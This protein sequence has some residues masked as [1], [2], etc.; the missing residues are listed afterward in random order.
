MA[1]LHGLQAAEA[2]RAEFAARLKRSF[3]DTQ[4]LPVVSLPEHGEATLGQLI[5]QTLEFTPSV[6]AVRRVAQQNG[7][8]LIAEADGEQQTTMLTQPSVQQT[9]TT[10]VAKAEVG[11]GAELYLKVGRKVARVER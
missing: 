6:S 8:R 1:A 2:A 10:V 4:N 5:S 9:L 11:E 3:G 7:L